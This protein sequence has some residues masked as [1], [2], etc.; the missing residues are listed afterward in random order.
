VTRPPIVATHPG[1]AVTAR[2]PNPDPAPLLGPRSIAIV[3]ANDRPGSY[4]DIV[5]GNLARAGFG[6]NVWGVN[7]RRA[8]VHGRSCVPSVADLPE[9]V[10]AVVVA[11]PAA[12]VPGVIADTIARGC[13]GAIVISAGFGE[14]AEGRGLEREVRDLA[15]AGGLPICGPNG[16]GIVAGAASAPMWGDSVPPL[17]PGGVAMISQSGNVAVNALGSRRGIRYHTVLSTGNQ[18]VLDAS[19]WLR[20][21]CELD[22]VGSIAMFLEEDGD[23]ERLAEALARCADR[24]I[25]VAILKAAASEAGARAASAHTGAVAGDQRVFRALVAE[26]GAAWASDPHE[27]LELARVLAEPRARPR[28]DGGLAILTCS[29]GDSSLAADEAARIGSELPGLAPETRERL[30]ELLPGAATVGNPLDYTAVIWGDTDLLRR[31]TVTVGDDPSI[32]QLLVL[33]DH[34]QG[35][36]PEAAESWAAV[37]AGIVAGAGETAAATL[38]ASTLPDL[39][40]DQASGELADRGVPAIAG[41]RTAL[42]CA[43]ALRARGGDPSRLLEIAAAA[44]PRGEPADPAG[45][46][47]WMDEIDAKELLR[48][49]GLPVPDARVVAS[50]DECAAALAEIGGAV[51][52]KL[53]APSLRH[54]T[55]VGAVRL[56]V[57]AADQARAAFRELS[58]EAAEGTRV[59]VERM[60]PP[61]VELLVSA[62]GDAVVPA[63]VVGLGGIWAEAL[64]DVAI[65]PVPASAER[66]R[67]AIGSLRGAPLLTGGRGRGPLDV[68]AAAILAAAVGSLLLEQGLDLIELNP[69]VVHEVGCTA[70]DAVARRRARGPG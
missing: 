66:V 33:Y 3:G 51:A 52:I 27:L 30:D 6:G 9:P 24:G 32:D 46:D 53:A 29:G 37:R 45:G 13:G 65:V 70:V 15:L 5:L 28:G 48:R 44:R 2:A 50:E 19:D 14:I 60:A 63:L 4:G 35:L 55:E 54:K 1:D 11:I 42:A 23:G 67:E 31:I 61:G 56:D 64:D 20:A 68:D 10:D 21:V 16:N 40:D 12:G 41:L 17:E 38:V 26:A 7:P 18:T 34:P 58:S 62:R 25:G 36:S 8:E 57:R 49:A 43:R 59:L 39:I 22:G 47:G 69:V